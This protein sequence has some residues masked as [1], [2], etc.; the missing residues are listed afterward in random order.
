M[1]PGH[2]SGWVG[3]GDMHGGARVAPS[4]SNVRYGAGGR[5]GE[6]NAGKGGDKRAQT[7]APDRRLGASVLDLAS[8]KLFS[9]LLAKP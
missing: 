3:W 9:P 6:G 1:R 7:S 4:V 2:P 8:G 5:G